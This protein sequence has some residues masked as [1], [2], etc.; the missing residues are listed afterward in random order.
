MTLVIGAMLRVLIIGLVLLVGAMFLRPGAQRPLPAPVVATVL[1]DP[2]LLP[3]VSL[4]D[5]T[6]AA[7]TTAN[8]EDQFSFLFFGFTHCPDICPTTLSTLAAVRADWKATHIDL[9]EV[10][11]VS[12]DPQRDDPA[13]ISEYL[14]N[15]DPDFHGVTGSLD[16]LQPWLGALGVTVQSQRGTGQN[17]YNVTHN[18][19][20]YV[21]GPEARLLAVFS[22]PHEAAIIAADF[23]KIRQRYLRGPSSSLDPAPSS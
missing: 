22:A 10:V 7:F 4:T 19:T 20:I 5:K 2:S 18:S 23:L 15:F 14:Q 3:A 9:P 17:N 1:A 8:L 12:V 16:A 13:R 11:F 21:V 6:G